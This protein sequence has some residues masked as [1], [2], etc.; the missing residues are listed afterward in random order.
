MPLEADETLFCLLAMAAVL[1]QVVQ[2]F[3]KADHGWGS[4]IMNL[5]PQL[6]TV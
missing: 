5:I 2:E 1:M 6:V 3:E 4:S